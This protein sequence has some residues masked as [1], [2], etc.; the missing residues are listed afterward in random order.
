[1]SVCLKASHIR[2]QGALNSKR[3]VQKHV[4]NECF[5]GWICFINIPTSTCNLGGKLGAYSLS[6]TN[7]LLCDQRNN[8]RAR[9]LSSAI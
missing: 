7:V 1:M 6:D 4:F 8:C 5:T 2:N 3:P 9:Y